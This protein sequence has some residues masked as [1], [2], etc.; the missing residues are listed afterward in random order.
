MFAWLKNLFAEKDRIDVYRPRERLVYSFFTGEKT[1]KV[2]PLVYYKKIMEI[3][4]E[5]SID[6]KVA[7]SQSKDAKKAHDSYVAKI[8]EVF[9]IKAFS[10]GGLSDIECAELL[11]H[12]LTFC[13]TLKK[14]TKPSPTPSKPMED[15]K[16][17]SPSVPNTESIL[18]SGSIVKEPSIAKPEPRPMVLPLP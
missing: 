3:G 10:N 2:D 18:D 15:S 9:G 1:I 16:S 6:M 14:N 17:T 4:P 13:D 8:R 11:D 5:L 7:N 12:F